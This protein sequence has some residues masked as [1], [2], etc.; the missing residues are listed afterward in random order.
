MGLLATK[1]TFEEYE[2]TTQSNESLL[3]ETQGA[4]ETF[5]SAI[6]YM[7]DGKLSNETQPNKTGVYSIQNEFGWVTT[8]EHLEAL[9]NPLQYT[10]LKARSIPSLLN[11]IIQNNHLY[12]RYNMSYTSQTHRKSDLRYIVTVPLDFDDVQL[13]EL[14]IS[15]AIELKTHINKFGFEVFL[16]IK[17]DT[18]YHAHLPIEPLK[19]MEMGAKHYDLIL[20]KIVKLLGSDPNSA[21]AEHFF[22]VPNSKNV[23]NFF[24]IEKPKLDFYENKLKDISVRNQEAKKTDRLITPVLFG[25]NMNQKA[26]RELLKGNFNVECYATDGYGKT[27]KC[28]R[29]NAC[30]SVALGM[31]ADNI[32]QSET[33][34][35]LLKWREE[36]INNDDFPEEEV[37]RII[38][39]AY[40]G[41]YEGPGKFYVEALT[42]MSF[43]PYTIPKARGKRQNHFSEI[44]DDLIKYLNEH[45]R[46]YNEHLEMSQ[47][48]LATELSDFTGFLISVDSLKKVIAQMKKEEM[49]EI[50]TIRRGKSYISIYILC[51]LLSAS[52]CM[53]EIQDTNEVIE[54]N[55]EELIVENNIESYIFHSANAY[56]YISNANGSLRS[57]SLGTCSLKL[58]NR[59]S[60][61]SRNRKIQ[62]ANIC[63]IAMWSYLFFFLDD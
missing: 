55:V 10:H 43:I 53:I 52:G 7:Y 23:V 51:D 20:K 45:Y 4:F 44:R 26:M 40:S 22:R 14:N 61:N 18:G 19:V 38:S 54:E 48:K 21:S 56:T 41:K 12:M 8:P 6:R 59:T 34:R 60:T 31:F 37:L 62:T 2:E 42:G 33:R 1:E 39:N 28:G 24:N 15:T 36:A 3:I 30:L 47:G 25:K 32:S 11:K 49:L 9:R 63:S 29:N 16:I 46:K 57:R 5:K 13:E 58:N 17:T 27:R 35:V 50:K